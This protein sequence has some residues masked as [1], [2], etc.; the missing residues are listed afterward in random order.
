MAAAAE[1]SVR[2]TLPQVFE[3]KALIAEK[4]YQAL[5]RQ[6]PEAEAMFARDFGR[7]KDIF[8]SLLAK[9]AQYSDQPQALDDIASHLARVHRVYQIS[10]VQYQA[11]GQALTDAFD[12]AMCDCLS[13]EERARW[14]RVTDR[15]VQRIIELSG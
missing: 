1:S 5:F 14:A 6:M 8:A 2:D 13:P 10:P 11:A 12:E 9:V 3:H 15:L 7:Q 4:F